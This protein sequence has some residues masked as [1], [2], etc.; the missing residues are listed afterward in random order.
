MKD[1]KFECSRCNDH[2]ILGRYG[3]KDKGEPHIVKSFCK[4]KAGDKKAFDLINKI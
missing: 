1:K 3:N 2:G 4:C